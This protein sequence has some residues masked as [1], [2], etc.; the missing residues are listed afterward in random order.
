MYIIYIYIWT[1][2][3]VESILRQSRQVN[4]SLHHWGY[5][6][7]KRF[8]SEEEFTDAPVWRKLKS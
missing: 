5:N 3:S 6:Q 2:D 4:D 7:G 1:P 8:L